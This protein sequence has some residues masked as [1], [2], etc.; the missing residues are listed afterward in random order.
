MSNLTSQRNAPP[1]LRRVAVFFWEGY[2]GIAP[3]IING[4]RILAEAGFQVDVFTRTHLGGFPS[5][6][7]FGQNLRVFY[8][9]IGD[10]TRIWDLHDSSVP[11]SSSFASGCR[12]VLP[13]VVIDWVRTACHGL[14]LYLA[15]ELCSFLW[16]SFR[17]TKRQPYVCMVGVDTLGFFIAA[18]LGTWFRTPR[19]FWSLE[20][21]FD[22]DLRDPI[23]KV[24]KHCERG[25]HQ[26][27]DVTIIQDWERA[28]SL[29]SSNRIKNAQ[30]MI[31]PNGPRG[32]CHTAR[33][34]FLHR[35]LDI[36]PNRK[37]ILHIGMI[38]DACLSMEIAA[39][40]AHWPEDWVLVCHSSSRRNATEDFL[41]EMR[42]VSRGRLVLSLEPV[43]YDELDQV[44]SSALIGLVFYQ[45]AMGPN[46]VQI[47]GASGKLGHYLRCGLPV[48][49]IDFKGLVDLVNRFQCG[50]CVSSPGSIEPAIT[51]IMACYEDYR[52]QAFRAY[53]ECFEFQRHFQPVVDRL[54]QS[55]KVA[56]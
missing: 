42:R 39:Q 33:S 26:G 44:V 13:K 11:C 53:E 10:S 21:S 9:G 36:S 37:I 50:I 8:H 23:R 35:R 6:P 14:G 56:V 31:V 30:I 54:L 47:A 25:F 18:L 40:A 3:S 27:A 49:T 16:Y 7:K 55:G 45:R 5:P 29:I 48:V 43:S 22:R 46:F 20:L 2:L 28:Q 4:I 41:C 1:A 17:Q 51:R 15:K 12:R 19:W 24:I 34:D 52:A 38:D 32:P